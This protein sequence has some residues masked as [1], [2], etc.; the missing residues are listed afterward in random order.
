MARVWGL[1]AVRVG[2]PIG[3]RPPGDPEATRPFPL[4]TL[5]SVVDARRPEERG[6]LRAALNQ[7]AEQDPLINVR[8]DDRGNDI[9]VSL[10]GE[11]QKE[12]IAATLERDYGIE[13]EFR[14]TTTLCIEW[15]A[16]AAEADEV[17]AAKTKTN[18]TGRSSPLSTNPFVATMGLRIE[19]LPLGSGIEVR[20]D[21]ESRL[22]PLFLYRTNEAFLAA[23]EANVREA[24]EEGLAGWPVTDCRVTMWDC[25]YTSPRSSVQDFRRLTQL[26]LATALERAGTWVCQPLAAISLELP[27]E[28]APGT[29][30]VLSRI[31]GRVTGQFSANGLSHVRGVLPVA[32]VRDLQHQLPGLTGGEAVL[33]TRF[34]GYQP[35]GDHPPRR[36]RSSPSPLQRDEWLAWLARRP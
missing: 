33:E 5:E 2:D 22:V 26:V 34:G 8:Q 6:S 1:G 29:L 12:V 14:D 31:G 13:A 24:L 7:L 15:P 23:M 17:I 16:R 21:V 11:V 35:V 20:L 32:R 3:V 10:Y 18:I 30:A 28:S 25:G 27:S 9:S 36:E 4:P 19:P